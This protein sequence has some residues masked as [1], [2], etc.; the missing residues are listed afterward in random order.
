[1]DFKILSTT[2]EPQHEPSHEAPESATLEWVL[3]HINKS[4]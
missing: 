1:M 4:T 3:Q 2:H